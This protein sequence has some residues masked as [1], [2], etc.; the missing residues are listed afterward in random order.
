MEN[1][2]WDMVSLHQ[3][4]K[5]MKRGFT[6]VEI[7]VAMIIMTIA[8]GLMTF[9]YVRAQRMRR[10]IVAYSEIQQILSQMADTIVN[11]KKGNLGVKFANGIAN[12]GG[13][14]NS[15]TSFVAYKIENITQTESIIVIIKENPDTKTNT[16]YA[17]WNE[18][19]PYNFDKKD[20][21]DVPVSV[22]L[23]PTI[24]DKKDLIDVNNKIELAADSKFRYFDANYKETDLENYPYAASKVTYVEIILKGKS[25]DPN[26]KS[27]APIIYKTSVK[28]KN[29][30]SF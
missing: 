7:L 1:K 28:L 5:K 30:L 10:E 22:L 8:F 21:E 16:L 20:L 23:S 6:I 4:R 18:N 17:K 9:M 15:D 26:L 14:T 11:G 27:K 3:K 24:I 12:V 29:N 19:P 25:T 13:W 2:K